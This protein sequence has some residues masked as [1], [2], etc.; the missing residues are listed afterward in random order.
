[1]WEIAE[2]RVLSVGM[3][4]AVVSDWS[5]SGRQVLLRTS[6]EIRRVR[7]LGQLTSRP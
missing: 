7:K 3:A 4:G 1:M 6:R 5:L 2:R